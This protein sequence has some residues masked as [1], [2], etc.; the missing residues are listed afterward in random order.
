MKVIT[1]ASGSSGNAYLVEENGR[2]ILLDCGI[3]FEDIT[4]SK[5]FPGFRKL[6]LVFVS[7]L[8]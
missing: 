7:H 3:K 6:D 8:H 4:G 2:Y 5:H 1:L